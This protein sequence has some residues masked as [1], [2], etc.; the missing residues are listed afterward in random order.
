MADRVYVAAVQQQVG[1]SGTRGLR[2]T[3]RDTQGQ[4]GLYHANIRRDDTYDD[5]D[6]I[7]GH[8]GVTLQNT[9]DVAGQWQLTNGGAGAD[10]YVGADWDQ[11][12]G[13]GQGFGW[14]T[15]EP[16]RIQLFARSSPGFQRVGQVGGSFGQRPITGQAAGTQQIAEWEITTDGWLVVP[17]VL[18]SNDWTVTLRPATIPAD[19]DDDF[20]YTTRSKVETV[21]RSPTNQYSGWEASFSSRVGDVIRKT[22]DYIDAQLGTSF[23]PATADDTRVYQV[24]GRGIVRTEDIDASQNVSLSVGDV[25]LA[26]TDF[27]WDRPW[28]RHRVYRDLRATAAGASKLLPGAWVEIEGRY[29]WPSVPDDVTEY[30]TTLA[31]MIFRA[32]DFPF[33]VLDVGTYARTAGK[34][35]SHFLGHYRRKVT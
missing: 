27:A 9:R 6:W 34:D 16:V 11:L 33:G 13:N 20:V 28:P 24:G 8:L 26:A 17:R 3:V 21:L 29:G 7:V 32:A 14:T 10:L 18:S 23:R 30:A 15:G 22:Q 25:A 31:A 35:V 19:P 1:G 2:I 12:Q 5:G 4:I